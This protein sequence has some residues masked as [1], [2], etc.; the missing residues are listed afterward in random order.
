MGLKAIHR[1]DIVKLIKTDNSSSIDKLIREFSVLADLDGDILQGLSERDIRRLKRVFARILE[2]NA[3]KTIEGSDESDRIRGRA[4]DDTLNG[5]GGNDRVIGGAGNDKMNGG[6]GNDRMNGGIGDDMMNGGTGN[7]RMNGGIGDD[8]MNGGAGNDKMNGGAGNDKMNG[9]AGND[10]LFDDEPL[11]AGDFDDDGYLLAETT[12]RYGNDKINGG[13]GDDVIKAGLGSDVLRGGAGNDRLISY[14]DS[15]TPLENKDIPAN[16]EDGDDV[17]KLV[18]KQ[19]FYNPDGHRANDKLI[20]G[21]GADTFEFRLLINAK[22]D[23]IEEHTNDDGTIEWGM[24][25]VA[26]ENDNYHDH[27]VDGIGFD[28]VMDFSG[29]GGDGDKIVISGHTVT[30]KVLK[31]TDRVVRLGIYSDQG[32]DG[33]RGNGAHDLDVLGRIHIRHDGNFSLND[34]KVE[35]VDYGSF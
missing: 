27:W 32:G 5:N 2:R 16:T 28:R 29:T 23:I 24:N 6:A 1:G 20:G 10:K 11:T 7:D 9:G 30:Y 21:A 26:G 14:S 17:D 4:G 33:A 19:E 22:K 35:P 13:A 15:N 8:M 3:D 34:I 25:G 31:E 18:F 12:E